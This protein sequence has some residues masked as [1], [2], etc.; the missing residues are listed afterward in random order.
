[1]TLFIFLKIILASATGVILIGVLWSITHQH[2][3]QIIESTKPMPSM[4][5][6]SLHN[7]TLLLPPPITRLLNLTTVLNGQV[8]EYRSF[9]CPD[10]PGVACSGF[11]P[12]ANKTIVKNETIPHNGGPQ[13]LIPQAPPVPP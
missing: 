13:P 11:Y 12:V 5:P 4:V 9:P 8:L 1:M 3:P 7:K 2:Q 10:N 6:V